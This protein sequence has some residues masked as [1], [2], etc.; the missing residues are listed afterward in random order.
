MHALPGSRRAQVASASLLSFALCLSVAS[1]QARAA[2][3]TLMSWNLN[4]L[5]TPETDR[6][7][8]PVCKGQQPG[9]DTR[10]LPCTPGRT[11]P[12]QRTTADFEALARVAQALRTNHHADVVALQEVDGPS[13]ARMAFKEGWVADCFIQRAHPQK[14]GF[15]IRQGVPY[16]CNGD[17]TA[18]DHDGHS[19]AGADITL[20]PDSP[21]AVRLLAV[22][23]K[24]GCFD[25]K[26]DRSFSPCAGLRQQV[27][28]V[29]RWIDARVREGMPFAVLGDFNRHLDKDSR[30]SA[31]PDD[32]APL[33]VLPAWSDDNPPGA[34]LTRATDGERYVA[35]TADDTHSR[36]ID[37]VLLSQS[38]MRR[39]TSSRFVRPSFDAILGPDVARTRQ[40]SDHCPVGITLEMP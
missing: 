32:N 33:N 6:E 22:H 26:L 36:Y 1:T 13:A 24:S 16:R 28:I 31:G 2:S 17:Y 11:P 30:Y 23:L 7:L 21:K 27:P 38:L 9:S 39:T 18:L 12:P 14:V 19:R 10:A 25:G 37:D 4:W 40:V 5:I 20:W 3:L 35:C 15:A 34:L 29:E 8:R